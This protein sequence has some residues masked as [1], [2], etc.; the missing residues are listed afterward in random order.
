MDGGSP[1]GD[2]TDWARWNEID[3]LFEALL[4]LDPATWHEALDRAAPDPTVRRTVLRLLTATRDP[5]HS[6]PTLPPQA[7]AAAIE[8]LDDRQPHAPATGSVFG[9]YRL[10]RRIGV[11]GMGAVYYAERA[12]ALFSKAAAVKLLPP[13]LASEGRRE[14]FSAER[15]ILARLQHPGIAALL[16]GGVTDDGVPY[17]IME[18]V[19]GRAIDQ[20]CDEQGLSVEERLRLFL[21]VCAAVDYAHRNLVVHRD[22]KP[23]NILVTASGE[24]KLLDFGIALLLQQEA[25]DAQ[26]QLTQVHGAALTPAYASP[27]Q[28]SGDTLTTA[29]DVYSL[30][31]LLYRLL[32]GRRPYDTAGLSA[33]QVER[34]VCQEV[35]R[36]PSETVAASNGDAPHASDER[37]NVDIP[38]RRLRGDLDTIVMTALH[39]EPGRRYASAR[40]L[41]DDI[42]RHLSGHP[43]LARPDTFAY[44]ASRFAARNRA[45]VGAAAAI[46]LFLVSFSGLAAY[47]AVTTRA[48]NE[49]I[50]SERDRAQ[51]ESE[52]AETVASFMVGLFGA[53][54]PDVAAGETVTAYQLLEQGVRDAA[55]AGLAAGGAGAR[56]G[57]HRPGLHAPRRV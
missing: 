44:R 38:A 51:L 48:Q 17:F 49:A 11:G 26:G 40:A 14:R 29:A 4:D 41:A 22:L 20:Y 19:D 33:A 12:D 18:Y 21:H 45:L 16:D 9:S 24:V 7:A 47:T 43:V 23:S 25:G 56:A 27:E 28:V 54:D 3:A 1:M 57:R 31:V 5:D 13:A 8:A 6:G 39:K 15:R 10:G 36:L 35:P 30:G 52:K 2:R 53:S 46:V 50:A 37:P 55:S 32:T 34:V 42:E